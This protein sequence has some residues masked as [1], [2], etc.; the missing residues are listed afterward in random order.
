[1]WA[2]RDLQE[3]QNAVN[4]ATAAATPFPYPLPPHHH[5]H[6]ETPT[7][8][9]ATTPLP[10]SALASL[11][12]PTPTR[13]NS[14]PVPTSV[15][16]DPGDD[17]DFDSEEYEE[18]DSDDVSRS[19]IYDIPDIPGFPLRPAPTG[20]LSAGRGGDGG[21]NGV[22]SPAVIGSRGGGG[23]PGSRSPL[24]M[25]GGFDLRAAFDI[26]F[27]TAGSDHA[28][29]NRVRTRNGKA[30]RTRTVTNASQHHG[31]PSARTNDEPIP[32]SV[33]RPPVR[34]MTGHSETSNISS[35]SGVST[36][37]L[38]GSSQAATARIMT[39]PEVQVSDDPEL[40]IGLRVCEFNIGCV[41]WTI[42]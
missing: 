24:I 21:K 10:L 31:N 29:G 16:S 13:S 22:M 33:M 3:I 28:H 32:F 20:H 27:D 11:D 5:H 39:N 38:A 17:S 12:T 26:E 30:R 40:S 37:L 1:M 8:R 9:G 19:T 14:E 34:S 6:H 18:D 7:H 35:V 4:R 41:L 2:G 25:P 15:R 42:F 36:S 23:A